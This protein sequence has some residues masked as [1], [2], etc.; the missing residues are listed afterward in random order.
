[1]MYNLNN[2]TNGFRF[3]TRSTPRRSLDCILFSRVQHTL[4]QL[5]ANFTPWCKRVILA[6]LCYVN[7]IVQR[8][9]NFFFLIHTQ[10]ISQTCRANREKTGANLMFFPGFRRENGEDSSKSIND[11]F[12]FHQRGTDVCHDSG[13]T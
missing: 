8:L 6:I 1:M 11:S 3:T 5:L 12:H 9:D 10:R 2:S 13:I 7:I 4:A